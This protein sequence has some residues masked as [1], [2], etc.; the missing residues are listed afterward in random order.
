MSFYQAHP[1]GTDV[2]RIVTRPIAAGQ[3]WNTGAL[4]ILD[5]NGAFVECGAD[6]ALVAAVA[7]APTGADTSGFNIL[8][9]KAFPPGWAQAE[10]VGYRKPFCAKYV[11]TL[12]AAD[13]AEYGV[14]RDTDGLWKVDFAETTA[15]V[16]TL[17]DRRTTSPENLGIVVVRFREAIVQAI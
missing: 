8:G 9:Q 12:P 5:A 1:D 11:G 16:V 15:K 14:V 2:P 4:L 3:A 13:G 6:P 17:V 10:P 7:L